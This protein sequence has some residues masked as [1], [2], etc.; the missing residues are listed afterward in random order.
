[1]QNSDY[2]RLTKVGKFRSWV[3]GIRKQLGRVS[4]EFP[5]S[6][7]GGSLLTTCNIYCDCLKSPEIQ[8]NDKT[9][10]LLTMISPLL[11]VST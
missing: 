5:R 10:T 4:F 1:M 6:G 2:Q 9:E 7:R 8:G 3:A 11:P